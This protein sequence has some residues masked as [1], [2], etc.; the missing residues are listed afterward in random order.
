MTFAIYFVVKVTIVIMKITYPLV[1]PL[2]SKKKDP[3]IPTSSCKSTIGVAITIT[4]AGHGGMIRPSVIARVTLLRM[5][6]T[7]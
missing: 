5:K 7:T 2:L 3:P 1:I 4:I 6:K